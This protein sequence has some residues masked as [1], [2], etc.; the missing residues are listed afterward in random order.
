MSTCLCV[1]VSVSVCKCLC[2]YVIRLTYPLD[3]SLRRL[4]TIRREEKQRT[5]AETA[6][7]AAAAAAGD[8]DDDD[9]NLRGTV[10]YTLT[11]MTTA[12]SVRRK[13]VFKESG[14]G[15]KFRDWLKVYVIKR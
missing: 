15:Y 9:D 1:C 2:V 14:N 6:E 3:I 11:E 7:A 13:F 10:S 5:A 4:T 8:N 12:F